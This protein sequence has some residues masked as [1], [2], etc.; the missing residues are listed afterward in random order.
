MSNL[1]ICSTNR[2]RDSMV[3]SSTLEIHLMS[4]LSIDRGHMSTKEKFELQAY[5]MAAVSFNRTS[6]HARPEKQISTDRSWY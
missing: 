6:E 2:E 4:T 1:P 5:C 3:V